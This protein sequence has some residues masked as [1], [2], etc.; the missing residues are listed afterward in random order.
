MA[1]ASGLEH[2]ADQTQHA[3]MGYSLGY[4]REKFLVNR[5]PEKISEIRVHDPLRP[6]LNLFPHFAQSI[7]RGSPSPISEAGVIEDRFDANPTSEMLAT[8]S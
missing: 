2:R 8:L 7:L 6:A 1:I 3:A 4:Q 5:R